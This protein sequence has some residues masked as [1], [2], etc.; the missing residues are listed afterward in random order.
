M[1]KKEEEP[2]K[3]PGKVGIAIVVANGKIQNRLRAENANIS[4]MSIAVSY[5]EM[6]KNHLL[7]LIAKAVQE[8]MNRKKDQ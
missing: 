4:D 2:K 1:A 5:L 7:G 8:E 6:N 3:K